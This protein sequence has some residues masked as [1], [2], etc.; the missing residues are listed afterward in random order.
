MTHKVDGYKEMSCFWKTTRSVIA[1]SCFVLIWFF[2]S[3]FFFFY[4]RRV[5]HSGSDR[6]SCILGH[7]RE[8]SCRRRDG[9]GLESASSL[10]GCRLEEEGNGWG[11][12]RDCA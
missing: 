9:N 4:S 2:F 7:A 1:V 10:F 6:E 8:P 5:G 11:G 3:I 12:L